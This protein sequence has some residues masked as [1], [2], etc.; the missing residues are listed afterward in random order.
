MIFEPAMGWEDYYLHYFEIDGQRYGIPDEDFETDDLS[1]IDDEG[2]VFVDVIKAPKRLFYEY[3][4]GEW[5]RH[6]V[7]IESIDLVPPMLKFAICLDGQPACPP[8]V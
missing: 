4:F 5:W 7:V 1:D 2:F 3:H 6:E 8:E